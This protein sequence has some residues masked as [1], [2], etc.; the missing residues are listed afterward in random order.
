MMATQ[1]I[2][3]ESFIQNSAQKTRIFYVYYL[4]QGIVCVMYTYIFLQNNDNILCRILISLHFKQ[5][6][7]DHILC[8]ILIMFYAAF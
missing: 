6:S 2:L 1:I 7:N 8:R 3:V 5:N 4:K